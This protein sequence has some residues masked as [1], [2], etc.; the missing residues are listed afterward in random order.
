MVLAAQLGLGPAVEVQHYLVTPA[1]DEQRRRGRRGQPGAS[2][3]GAAAAGHHDRDAGAGLGR[4]S[5]RRRV[6]GAGAEVADSGL[7]RAPLGAAIGPA[8]AAS[9]RS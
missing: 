7:S 2:Q 8:G 1:D 5:Q 6:A 9:G 4:R 3:I